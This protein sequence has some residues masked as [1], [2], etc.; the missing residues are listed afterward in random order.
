[1]RL[2]LKHTPA[3][4]EGYYTQA[5]HQSVLLDIAFP[6]CMGVEDTSCARMQLQGTLQ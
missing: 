2:R 3:G 6:G 1:M 5:R 4:A